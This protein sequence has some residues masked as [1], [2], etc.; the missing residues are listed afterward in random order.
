MIEDN[1]VSNSES[2]LKNDFLLFKYF[3]RLAW[4]SLNFVTFVK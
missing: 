4:N 1:I 2:L 3:F